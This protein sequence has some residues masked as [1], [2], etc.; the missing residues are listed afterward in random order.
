M[1]Y[2]FNEQERR[3]LK[4][5]GRTENGRDFAS[6]LKRAKNYYSSIAGIDTSKDTNAQIEG[7][8]LFGEFVDEIVTAIE[9]KTHQIRPK[10]HDDFT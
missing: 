9:T 2:E 8:K 3:F 4:E 1:A 10:E 7:R 5:I 6:L